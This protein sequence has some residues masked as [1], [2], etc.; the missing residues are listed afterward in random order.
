MGHRN[1]TIVATLGRLVCA[2]N[3]V[4]A[5]KR[6]THVSANM[7]QKWPQ[8]ARRNAQA[9]LVERSRYRP[10]A[11]IDVINQHQWWCGK[12]ATGWGWALD[13]AW[14]CLLDENEK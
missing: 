10:A 13:H 7:L 4:A 5:T 1:E 3:N 14:V 12:L 8:N 9:S 11:H 6:R 2:E